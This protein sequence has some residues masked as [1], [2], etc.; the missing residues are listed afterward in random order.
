MYNNPEQRTVCEI[1]QKLT[2]LA[3]DIATKTVEDLFDII[4]NTAREEGEGQKLDP[5]RSNYFRDEIRFEFFSKW[6]IKSFTKN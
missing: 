6:L 4:E 2:E 1:H 5:E 3:P